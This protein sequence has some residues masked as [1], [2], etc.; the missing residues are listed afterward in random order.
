MV[1]ARDRDLHPQRIWPERFQTLNC[2]GSFAP[3]RRPGLFHKAL[4]EFVHEL[5]G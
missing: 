4:L 2:S 5:G 3:F 1:D